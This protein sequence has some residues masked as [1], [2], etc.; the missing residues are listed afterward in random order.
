LFVGDRIDFVFSIAVF[1]RDVIGF[2]ADWAE[3]IFVTED[4]TELLICSAMDGP[5]LDPEKMC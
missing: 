5:L 4:F 1:T 2:V 3:G